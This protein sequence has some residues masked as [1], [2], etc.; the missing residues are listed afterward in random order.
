M[1]SSVWIILLINYTFNILYLI[2]RYAD[3]MRGFK[4]AI[5][6]DLTGE[7]TLNGP[8]STGIQYGAMALSCVEVMASRAII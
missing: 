1:F 7:N 6:R 4:S 5:E 3:F 8:Y 2:G